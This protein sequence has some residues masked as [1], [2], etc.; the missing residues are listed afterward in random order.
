M[1]RW[2]LELIW[3][4]PALSRKPLTLESFAHGA[5]YA[6]R[7][8]MPPPPPPTRCP[9]GFPWGLIQGMEAAGRAV[10]AGEAE[11]DLAARPRKISILFLFL[12]FFLRCLTSQPR[13]CLFARWALD[14]EEQ[15]S[16]TMGRHFLLLRAPCYY[17][18]G[19]E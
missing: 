6:P 11:A 12:K 19:D 9:S 3:N 13:H 2:N 17:G 10:V 8:T 18:V 7:L 16:A 5:H 4:L 1:V 15:D 14:M